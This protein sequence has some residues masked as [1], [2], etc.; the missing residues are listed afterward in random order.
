[1]MGKS[2]MP[3]LPLPPKPLTVQPPDGPFATTDNIQEWYSWVA[4]AVARGEISPRRGATV[5]KGVRAIERTMKAKKP[6][7]KKKLK[8]GS[9]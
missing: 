9:P 7:S 3:R 2:H 5:M 8:G 1:M 4:G 6:Q